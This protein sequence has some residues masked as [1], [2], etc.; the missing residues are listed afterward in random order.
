M[1]EIVDSATGLEGRV[2]TQTSRRDE[3]VGRRQTSG[4]D[5]IVYAG[6]W[7]RLAAVCIDHLLYGAMIACVGFVLMFPALLLGFMSMFSMTTI[8]IFTIT[9]WLGVLALLV[10]SHWLYYAGFEASSLQATPGKIALGLRVCD[11]HFQRLTLRRSTIR[12]ISHFL[13]ALL[14]YFGYL[15]SFFTAKRQ[16]LHDL[17]SDSLVVRWNNLPKVIMGG[18]LP[19]PISETKPELA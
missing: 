10:G 13:S 16:T 12:Y 8:T 19:Q 5:E 9:L 18:S 17:I 6:F 7:R 15:I 4:M 11:E 14:L 1:D 3:N 2:Q